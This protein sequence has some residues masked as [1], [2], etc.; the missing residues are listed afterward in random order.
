MWNR[1]RSTV[2]VWPCQKSPPSTVREIP[3][4]AARARARI[5]AVWGSSHPR[6]GDHR[7]DLMTP[8]ARCCA[9]SRVSRRRS[10]A[11]NNP[12]GAPGALAHPEVVGDLRDR[13]LGLLDDPDGT[14]TELPAYFLRVS[15]I[16]I[17]ILWMP[18][19][20]RGTSGLTP[21]SPPNCPK[22][23][24]TASKLYMSVG[25]VSSMCVTGGVELR[26]RCL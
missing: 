1:A 16:S 15:G 10:R 23:P 26:R 11:V 9:C 24:I 7:S 25:L 3:V 8:A 22:S 14:L 4:P 18:P 2:S 20:L 13:L 21:S 12:E 5:I 17:L 6:T 19:L